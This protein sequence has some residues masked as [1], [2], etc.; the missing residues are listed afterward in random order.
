MAS[1]LPNTT[2]YGNLPSISQNDARLRDLR[3]ELDRAALEQDELRRYIILVNIY[4]KYPEFSDI[5]DP[6]KPLLPAGTSFKEMIMTAIPISAVYMSLDQAATYLIG[7]WKGQIL[8]FILFLMCFKSNPLFLSPYPACL[9]QGFIYYKVSPWLA[10]FGGL[11]LGM[12]MTGLSS[13]MARRFYIYLFIRGFDGDSP[14]LLLRDT[15]SVLCLVLVPTVLQASIWLFSLYNFTE[16]DWKVYVASILFAITF[17]FIQPLLSKLHGFFQFFAEYRAP[18]VYHRCAI[19]LQEIRIWID[20][21]L[22]RIGFS[23]WTM[24]CIDLKYPMI[25]QSSNHIRLLEIGTSKEMHLLECKLIVHSLDEPRSFDAISYRWSNDRSVPIMLNNQKF[26]TSRTLYLLLRSLQSESDSSRCIWIDSICINQGDV[27]EKGWQ[28]GLMERIYSSATKV[29]GWMGDKAASKGALSF[30]AHLEHALNSESPTVALQA[31]GILQTQTP[32]RHHWSWSSNWSAVQ[33]LLRNEWFSRTWIIQE[34]A[35]ANDLVLQH[36]SEKISWETFTVV[37]EFVLHPEVEPFLRDY[38]DDWSG[39]NMQL[40]RNLSMSRSMNIARQLRKRLSPSTNITL[41]FMLSLTSSFRATNTRDKI[42]GLLGL[43]S[44]ATRNSIKVNYDIPIRDLM[45]DVSRFLLLQEPA[46][47]ESLH[48]AGKSPPHRSCKQ[49]QELELPSWCPDWLSTTPERPVISAP[50]RSAATHLQSRIRCVNNNDEHLIMRGCDFDTL[51]TCTPELCPE[52]L[53][54]A[55]AKG[56]FALEFDFIHAGVSVSSVA[57]PELYQESPIHLFLRTAL[58]DSIQPDEMPIT[59]KT[60][61]ELT[62]ALDAV[63]TAFGTPGAS[64]NSIIGQAPGM[65]KLTQ[66]LGMMA[67]AK[68]IAMTKKG[69]LALVP[70]AAEIGDHICIIYGAQTPMLVRP[71]SGCHIVPNKANNF[72][73]SCYVHGITHGELV[74]RE[75]LLAPQDL[76]FE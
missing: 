23:F 64:I 5:S 59:A 76:L 67:S 9:L 57:S 35:L 41:A 52:R 58:T 8:G 71:T 70:S 7:N 65:R 22:H 31:L 30:M 20:F 75:D 73:G 56:S 3:G 17:L 4:R 72:I 6:F 63:K 19:G 36:A 38:S 46:Q 12:A 68:K 61:D 34:V 37:A 54:Q 69:Y 28:I 24:N 47:L 43:V 18:Q 55:G 50:M 29:I 25:L 44:Q 53:L 14:R 39:V 45:I 15:M 11:N 74:G 48:L 27:Q 33:E 32:D 1:L 26:M 42:Y 51:S 49:F 16:A 21:T 66:A 13:M 10:H 2:A 62:T 40:Y 60:L